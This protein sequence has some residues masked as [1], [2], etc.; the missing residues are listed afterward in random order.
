[1]P[2][3]RYVRFHD[4]AE[5]DA[6][7]AHPVYFA[8]VLARTPQ[9]VLL[10]FNRYRQVWELPGGLVDP[11]ESAR[12]AALRELA[13]EAGARVSGLEWLGVTE[14]HDGRTHFGAVFR[15]EVVTCTPIQSD[16][17]AGQAYWNR[18]AGPQPLG[19]TDAALL[20]R[21]G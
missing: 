12:D 5:A 1:M 18:A 20:N 9:G 7:Q 4:V 15:G 10:V 21:F 3:A 2:L 19:N 16:E 17:I 14:V 11:G 6:A 13:E 8:V